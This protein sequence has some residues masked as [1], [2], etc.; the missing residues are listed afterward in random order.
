MDKEAFRVIER[1]V[2]VTRLLTLLLHI[3]TLGRRCVSGFS[4]SS[5]SL[6]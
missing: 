2:L 6:P 3:K 5:N 4:W 1:L